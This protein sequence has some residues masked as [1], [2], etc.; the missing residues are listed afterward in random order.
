MYMS[1]T[2][3]VRT[4]GRAALARRIGIDTRALAIFRISLGV[5]LLADLLLR[6]QNLVSFYT[7]SGVLPR[8]LLRAQFSGLSRLSIHALSGAT[9]FQ[10]TLFVVAGVFAVALLLGYRTRLATAISF[11]L[12][13]SLHARNPVLLNAGDSILRRLLLWG[14]FLPL[15]ERFSVD[16][17]HSERH[18]RRVVSLASAGVLLQVVTVYT[19]NALFKLRGDLWMRGVAVRY[20]FSLHNVLTRFGELLSNYP[21]ALDVFDRLWLVIVV[22]SVLL[23]LLTG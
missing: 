9:W 13:V 17:L 23:I 15:G 4:R 11:V 1:A 3:G 2:E 19:V 8:S 18:R 6:S 22:A 16:S 12:L 5:L 10:E 7:D 20:V 21:T 14:I